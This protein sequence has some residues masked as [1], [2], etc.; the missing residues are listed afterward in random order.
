MEIVNK[1]IEEVFNHGLSKDEVVETIEYLQTKHNTKIRNLRIQNKNI[2][3]MITPKISHA[4]DYIRLGVASVTHVPTRLTTVTNSGEKVSAE[5]KI[6]NKY[7]ID[8]TISAD[9]I[10]R[11][12][13][14]EEERSI[15]INKD[16]QRIVYNTTLCAA[17]D[18]ELQ[19]LY[20][21]LKTG[22]EGY[23]FD[24]NKC[25]ATKKK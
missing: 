2:L 22:L 4:G 12:E 5:T 17:N 21:Q 6:A 1:I 11:F 19:K 7:I 15:I 25:E 3:I 24:K 14:T 18:S 16:T 13:N 20:E 9:G 8:L 10:A 23:T